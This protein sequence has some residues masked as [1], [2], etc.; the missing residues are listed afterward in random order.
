MLIGIKSSCLRWRQ[1]TQVRPDDLTLPPNERG[2]PMQRKT[3]AGYEEKFAGFIRACGRRQQRRRADYNWKEERARDRNL[4][5]LK[6]RATTFVCAQLRGTGGETHNSLQSLSL[7]LASS[8]WQCQRSTQREIVF[9][10]NLTPQLHH[11]TACQNNL[12]L[13]TVTV[14]SS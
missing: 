9:I 11:K 10:N 6:T 8:T 5:K 12:Q 1:G 14:F 7:S 2:N 4:C 13:R 3:P